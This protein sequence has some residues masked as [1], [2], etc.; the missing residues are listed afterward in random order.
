MRIKLRKNES[1]IQWEKVNPEISH[2][3]IIGTSIEKIQSL[4]SYG[5]LKSLT[6]NCESLI[7][8]PQLPTSVEVLKVKHGHPDNGWIEHITQL[9]DLKILQ[10]SFLKLSSLPDHFFD[11]LHNLNTL[12]LMGND[13]EALP[14]SLAKASQLTRIS[15]DK[16]SFK[17]L[18][19]F[20]YGMKSLSHLSLDD[21]DLSEDTK[22]ELHEQ[23]GMWF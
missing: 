12:D 21:N 18:P 7:K 5:S 4:S 23:F 15:L 20:I 22:K 2:L 13:L 8:F 9:K 1:T 6:L 11:H 10:L 3:E 19:H 16:N 17:S 14:A